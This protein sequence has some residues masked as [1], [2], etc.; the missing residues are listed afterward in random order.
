MPSLILKTLKTIKPR[1]QLHSAA[2]CLVC[3]IPA[4]EDRY[5]VYNSSVK[6]LR[7]LPPSPWLWIF[8]FRSVFGFIVLFPPSHDIPYLYHVSIP[9][10][11]HITLQQRQIIRRKNAE[12]RNELASR[13]ILW[14]TYWKTA[15]RAAGRHHHSVSKW[16][17]LKNS[18]E[19]FPHLLK[20]EIRTSK[21]FGTE[22]SVATQEFWN[23]RPFSLCFVSAKV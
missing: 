12:R 9:I 1:P 22:E 14:R 15:W 23:Q 4:F 11:F 16:D 17:S 10:P 20:M 13:F 19:M 3:S 7:H 21:P 6:R 18:L 8:N 5:V 2:E